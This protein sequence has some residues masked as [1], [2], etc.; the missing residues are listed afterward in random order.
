[1]PEIEKEDADPTAAFKDAAKLFKSLDKN[2]GRDLASARSDARAFVQALEI[3]PFE[4]AQTRSFKKRLRDERDEINTLQTLAHVP[5]STIETHV[6]S[7][8]N[9]S[10]ALIPEL[11]ILSGYNRLAALIQKY[12][13]HNAKIFI[14]SNAEGTTLKSISSDV[15]GIH[16][17]APDTSLLWDLLEIDLAAAR[18]AADKEVALLEKLLVKLDTQ[19]KLEESNPLSD[20]LILRHLRQRAAATRRAIPVGKDSVNLQKLRELTDF[21]ENT[22]NSIIMPAG[23][24]KGTLVGKVL[25]S[26]TSW[27][28][29]FLRTLRILPQRSEG[30]TPPKFLSIESKTASKSLIAAPLMST[31]LK[32]AFD[33][34]VPSWGGIPEEPHAILLNI[35]RELNVLFARPLDKLGE[36]N[37]DGLTRLVS[38]QLPAVIENFKSALPLTEVTEE[39]VLKNLNEQLT[40]ILNEVLRMRLQIDESIARENASYTSYLRSSFNV[41]DLTTS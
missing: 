38:D 34:F 23:Q 32:E 16:L 18:E 19:I 1:M 28:S 8:H 7:V 30:H 13:A 26:K 21:A 5:V 20:P 27:W 41:S 12:K 15:L 33:A 22:P 40:L 9:I 3:L 31:V 24:P 10:R 4:T 14:E 17:T 35:G 2:R 39:S 6:N 11:D 29:R 37:S 36:L 25:S